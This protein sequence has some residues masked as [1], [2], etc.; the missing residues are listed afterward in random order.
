[1]NARMGLIIFAIGACLLNSGCKGGMELNQ[2]HIVHTV[3]IDAGRNNGIKLTAEISLLSSSGQQPKGMQER[4]FYLSGEGSSLFEAA[5]LMRTKSD[6]SL[7]WGHATVVV[8]NKAVAEQ[9]IGKHIMALRRLR[10]FRN[11]TLIYV[12]EDKASDVLEATM[13]NAT[14][15]SQAL[16]GLSE[17]GENTALTEEK[18]L[19]D[20]YDHLINED[21]DIHV[22]AVQLLEDPSAKKKKLLK[23]IGIYA[24]D[25]DRLVGLMKS[26]ETKG[27]Y[28]AMG[29]LSGSVETI[30]CGPNQMIAFENTSSN[31]RVK[32]GLDADGNPKVHIEIN[33]DLNLASV[34]CE[35]REVTLSSIEEWE[36]ELNKSISDAVERFIAFS[37]KKNSDLLGI[38]ERMHRKYPKHWK[39]V[40]D[41]WNEIYPRTTFSVEVHS[42]IDH[43]NFTT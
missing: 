13:P 38:K 14:I 7:L 33:A 3:G 1:M 15:T 8:F 17:G 19:I 42:R 18:T 23:T 28:R 16:R 27:F 2:L 5:R 24:F 30:P 25:K 9:G 21:T 29:S 43:T 37:Q 12:T 6:R 22:P 36:K 10:E 11:S 4:T 35:T 34:Q 26:K 32:I 41:K 20:V 31:S 40:K 39:K